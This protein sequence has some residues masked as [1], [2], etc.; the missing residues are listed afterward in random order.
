M[1]DSVTGRLVAI[2]AALEMFA[3][4]ARRLDSQ[5]S[6]PFGDMQLTRSQV[7]ALFL[8]THGQQPVTPGRVAEALGVTP[9]AVTQLMAGLVSAGLV[10]QRRDSHDARRRV[11]VLSPAARTE[12]EDFERQ[13]L[14]RLAP[15]FDNL[16]D[17]ELETLAE[18]LARTGRT[19]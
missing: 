8:V 1:T 19:A 6:F 11:L 4:W 18:L 16:D 2:S 12:F 17:T 5:A 15:A 7:E 14:Q 13:L 3:V 9:G 10:E